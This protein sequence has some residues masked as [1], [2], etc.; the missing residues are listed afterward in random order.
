MELQ[1]LIESAR[2][3]S[4]ENEILSW[5][6][7]GAL[8]AEYNSLT[9]EMDTTKQWLARVSEIR[10]EAS[11]AVRLCSIMESQQTVPAAAGPNPEEQLKE[12]VKIC[13]DLSAVLWESTIR[14]VYVER[15]LLRHAA[16]ILGATHDLRSTAT[17]SAKRPEQDDCLRCSDLS[18]EASE[19]T[20]KFSN[21]YRFAERN[22]VEDGGPKAS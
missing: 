18:V 3:D 7:V 5:H 16:G 11:T 19:L 4:R 12:S 6:E 14:A 20:E 15:R 10:G 13:Q 17:T 21:I 8:K 22:D 1:F 9:N 2:F